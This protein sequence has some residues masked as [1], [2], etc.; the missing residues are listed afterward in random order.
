MY[1]DIGSTI[2]LVRPVDGKGGGAVA[3]V[4]SLDTVARPV[5]GDPEQALMLTAT[6]PAISAAMTVPGRARKRW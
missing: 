4:R 3:L 5:M 2:P 1:A 6:L